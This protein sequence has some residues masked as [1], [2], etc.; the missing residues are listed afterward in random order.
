MTDA[1]QAAPHR[2]EFDLREYWSIVWRW[3]WLALVV[4]LLVSL[5]VAWYVERQVPVYESSVA[6]R[7]SAREPMAMM[8]GTRLSWYGPSRKLDTQI[9]LI[10]ENDKL[11]RRA[12]ESLLAGLPADSPWRVLVE[13]EEEFYPGK[14]R[15]EQ[16]EQSDI[17]TV[18]VAAPDP[19]LTKYAVQ[20]LAETYVQWFIEEATQ[21]VK[22]TR[23]FVGERLQEQEQALRTVEEQVS[24]FE[25]QHPSVGTA[26]VYRDRLAAL[27][28]SLT[29]ILELYS[30]RHPQVVKLRK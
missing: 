24:A 1:R 27:E 26:S 22:N 30:E 20:A 21:E 8:E 3:K 17:I 7:L 14:L 4:F 15:A 16:L 29:E 6:V 11:H 12:R 5:S 13:S 25:R 23:D 9:K 28:V 19:Q 10:T 18:T 2:L